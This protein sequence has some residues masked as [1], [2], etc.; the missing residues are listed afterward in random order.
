MS[1]EIAICGAL[2]GCEKSSI[3]DLRVLGLEVDHPREGALQV[4]VVGIEPLDDEFRVV[5]VLG[6]DDR[7]AEPGRRRRP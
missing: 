7:L 3:S 2:S 1:T 4:R 6:E 5:V